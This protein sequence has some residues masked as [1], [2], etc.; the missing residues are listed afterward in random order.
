MATMVRAGRY[1]IT[2]ELGRGAMG[3]VYRAVDPVIG[4]NVAV[5]TIRLS[6]EGTGLTRQE[7]LKR[8][9]TE[10]RAAGLL[11]HP[12]IVV[13]YDAGEENG[14]F[15]ITM[16][17]VEGQS[18]QSLLDSGHAFPVPRLLRILEQTCSA[19]QFA[20]E[21]SVVHRDIKPANLMLTADDTVKVTDFGTAKILQFGTAQQTTHVMGTP[22]YMSP[23]QVKGRPVDGRSDIFSLGVMFYEMLTGEKPFP[24]QSVTTVIYKIV[25]ED[26]IPPR[27]LNPSIHPGLNDIV[28]RALA[29]EPEYRYQTCRELQ[30]DL[31][32]YRALGSGGNNPDATMISARPNGPGGLIPVAGGLRGLHGDDPMSSPTIRSLQNR[33]SNPSQTP[34]IRRTGPVQPYEEPKKS[35]P[36]ATIFAA[37]VLLGV[38]IYGGYKL[39]PELQ[40][41]RERNSA[42][43][44][45]T[46]PVISNIPQSI[47][48]QP[49][50]VQSPTG[51][52][53]ALQ[54][55][56]TSNMVPAVAPPTVTTKDSNRSTLD[57]AVDH[58]GET[59]AKPAATVAPPVAEKKTDATEKPAADAKPAEKKPADPGLTPLAEDYKARIAEAASQQGLGNRVKVTGTGNTLTIS[60]KL[61]PQEHGEL[62]HF[63][64]NAPVALHV[65]DDIQYDDTPLPGS[66]KVNDGGHPVP[67]KGL[68]AIHIVTDVLGATTAIIGPAGRVIDECQT[69]CSF[70]DLVPDRYSLQIKK[71]GYQPVQTAL[72]LKTNES[73]DQKFHLESLAKGLAIT[74][75]PPG[76]EVFI[77]GALQPGRTPVTL[78]LASGQ[79][80]M[81]VRL[82]G[83]EAYAGQTQVKDNIQ[84]TMD[85]DLTPRAQPHVAWAQ[86]NTTPKGAEVFVDG[87]SSGQFSPA[88]IQISAGTHTLGLRLPGY[89]Q[90]KR[91]IQ[92]TEGGTVTVTETLKSDN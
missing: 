43:T 82:A 35:S 7:L 19:L 31:K 46:P 78:P 21:R 53:A 38:I 20:H 68:A 44:S 80:N 47:T 90:E 88:R 2:G 58:S 12:N 61:R 87:S 85:I 56:S 83:Y 50:D 71:D 33:L 67:R 39:R 22:S 48:T 77:N 74:T 76:A 4:R 64:R 9:Q 28:L 3:V 15:F 5:K 30:E 36:V 59:A 1:E 52:P 91:A 34:M 57:G 45:V 37:L 73:Q 42:N 55:G 49:T 63:M 18:V 8:F 84:T 14:L 75:R 66:E 27:Q 13:V 29:K 70:N 40:A 69:P 25:N 62:L 92:V 65:V 41:A 51:Q 86:V 23:E 60:G 10:A 32:N 16:E 54:P 24:G 11:T 26:P 89:Q 6:E 79:Y 81:V 17:L 72:Q